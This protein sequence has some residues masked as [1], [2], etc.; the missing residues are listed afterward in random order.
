MD[1]VTVKEVTKAI[2]HF[3]SITEGRELTDATKEAL[4]TFKDFKE[5]TET[6]LVFYY[7]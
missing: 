2:D 6:S 3:I 1:K 4:D 5:A 7:P